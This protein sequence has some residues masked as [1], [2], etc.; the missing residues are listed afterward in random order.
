MVNVRRILRVAAVQEATGQSR[1]GLYARI[2]EGL[3]P[4]P[5]KIGPRAAGWPDDEVAAVQ[6]AVIAGRPAQE[7][8][9]LV[10][11]LEAARCEASQ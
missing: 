5:V 6:A 8:R 10:R 2:S 1:A 11:R 3:W 4:R 9:A 7:I